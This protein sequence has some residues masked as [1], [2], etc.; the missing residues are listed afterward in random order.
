MNIEEAARQLQSMF[1]PNARH[2]GYPEVK[3][4]PL[5]GKIQV[6]WEDHSARI[7]PFEEYRSEGDLIHL[8]FSAREFAATKFM[9]ARESAHLEQ[10]KLLVGGLLKIAEKVA[11][12]LNGE[13][14][15]DMKQAIEEFKGKAE[16]A[17]IEV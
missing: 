17:G 1:R 4:I 13:D 8:G 12:H 7:F 16:L 3:V 10:Y 15:E 6:C 14:A 2:H 9:Q 5:N 11:V